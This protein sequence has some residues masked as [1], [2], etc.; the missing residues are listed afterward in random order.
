MRLGISPGMAWWKLIYPYIILCVKDGPTIV[1]T[2]KALK[3]IM[4]LV[5]VNFFSG[6]LY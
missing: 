6:R 4:L 2:T 5:A 3:I 1:L